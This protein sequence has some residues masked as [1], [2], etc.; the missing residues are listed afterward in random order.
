[1]RSYLRLTITL[2]VLALPGCIAKTA[3]DVATAPVK[4]ASKGVDLATTSQSEADENRGRALRKREEELGRLERQYD[5]ENKDCVKGYENSCD[6][7]RATYNQI[8]DLL[9]TVPVEPDR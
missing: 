8:Q 1:M 3:F 2:A 5:K 6:A 4:I 7:A 9:P